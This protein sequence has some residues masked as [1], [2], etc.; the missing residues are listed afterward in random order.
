SEKP[1][2]AAPLH[3]ELEKLS[4]ERDHK[5]ELATLL[6]QRRNL[7]SQ[8]T[9]LLMDGINREL[10]FAKVFNPQWALDVEAFFDALRSLD[11]ALLDA[12]KEMRELE[13]RIAALDL[14]IS[15]FGRV[16]HVL[17]AD[18]EISVTVEKGGEHALTVDYMVPCALWRPIHRATL[19]EKSVKFE[20]EGAVWQASGED[21]ND[22]QLSFSTA[23]STQ[24]SEPPVMSEDRLRV[25]KRVDRK[26]DVAIR[27][28]AIQTTGEEQEEG[29]AEE[30]PGVDD[31]GETRL[32]GASSKATI[33]SDGRMYRV[34]IFS[35]DAPAEVDRIARPERGAVVHLR[36]RQENTSKLPVLAGPVDLLRGSGYVGRSTVLFIAPGEKFAIGWGV[37]DALRIKRETSEKRDTAKLTGKITITRTVELFLSNLDDKAATFTIEE[38]I[39]VSEIEQ[40]T[41]EVDSKESKPSGAVDAQ[42]IVSWKID[43]AANGTQAV[44][45]VYRLI[46]SSD[47][48]GI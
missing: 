9:T 30:L 35:F 7:V 21:W 18:I 47:V 20:C 32:L 3:A 23:R 10:P 31:G 29:G 26:V 44:K 25:Q 28:T 38:R 34:P 24:R 22:V 42:G 14:R 45:L 37:D 13:S 4:A 5:Q 43:I 6:E 2:D 16:D 36:S 41:I 17:A 19:G 15:E 8:A 1:G 33:L 11:P 40:V 39:P 12:Y 48:K 46:A 27:E